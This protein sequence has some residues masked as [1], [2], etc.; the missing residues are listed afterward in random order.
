MAIY[1]NRALLHPELRGKSN[2]YLVLRSMFPFCY[3]FPMEQRIAWYGDA[4]RPDGNGTG[5]YMTWPQYVAWDKS[6]SGDIH[7]GPF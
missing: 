3:F 2:S 5:M 4:V 1:D 7:V 6:D